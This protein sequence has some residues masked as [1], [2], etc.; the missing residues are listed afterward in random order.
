VSGPARRVLTGATGSSVPN[1]ATA[2][3]MVVI[4]ISPRVG[5]LECSFGRGGAEVKICQPR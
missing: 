3:L 2:L 1:S 4:E 5:I